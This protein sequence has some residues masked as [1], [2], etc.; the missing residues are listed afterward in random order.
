ME[1]KTELKRTNR[2]RNCWWTECSQ[3]IPNTSGMISD[4][5][6]M[7]DSIK[8]LWE[9]NR[10]PLKMVSK[11]YEILNIATRH[12]GKGL[13][14]ISAP[15]SKI[16]EYRTCPILISDTSGIY[17][18]LS[19]EI[20]FKP[21]TQSNHPRMTWNFAER[22]NTRFVGYSKKIIAQDKINQWKNTKLQQT[23]VLP[24]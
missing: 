23:L 5:F 6:D 4:T 7:L 13:H 17:E 11:N 9:K 15:N 20:N 16:L 19:G 1:R 3:Q 12:H 24:P 22:I 21:K 10:K 8:R 2:G 18:Q 14:Q